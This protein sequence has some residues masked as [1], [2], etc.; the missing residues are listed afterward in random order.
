MPSVQCARAGGSDGEG[1]QNRTHPRAAQR[2]EGVMALCR[3]CGQAVFL[4]ADA[5]EQVRDIGVQCPHCH[6]HP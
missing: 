4:S 6:Q 1:S 5:L 3:Q 2:E